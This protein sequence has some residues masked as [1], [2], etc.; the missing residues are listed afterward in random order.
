M[1]TRLVLVLVNKVRMEGKELNFAVLYT[2]NI[3]I[4]MFAEL[5]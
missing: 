4:L 1:K 3:V 2:I 5:Y